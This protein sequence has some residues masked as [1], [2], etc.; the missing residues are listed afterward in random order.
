MATTLVNVRLDE[1][2]K[3]E[4]ADLCAEL[5]LSMSTAFNLFAKTMVRERRIPFEI[6]ADPFYSSENMRHLERAAARMDAG[7]DA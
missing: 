4:M 1:A 5:G 2:T 6:T 3:K 7:L